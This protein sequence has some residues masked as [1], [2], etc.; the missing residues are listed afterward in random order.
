MTPNGE[1]RGLSAF[2]HLDIEV[3]S[4]G[5]CLRT[6]D[7]A[8]GNGSCAHAPASINSPLLPETL[9]SPSVLGPN[10]GDPGNLSREDKLGA[11]TQ[12]APCLG[13]PNKI[14]NAQ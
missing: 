8:F 4:G 11:G 7:Y 3:L 5:F 13:L 10:S 6:V 9:A 2:L 1:P 12:L 14:Q